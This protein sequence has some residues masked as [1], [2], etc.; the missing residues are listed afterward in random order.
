MGRVGADRGGRVGRRR[1]G[2]PI[3]I[4]MGF[5]GI[6]RCGQLRAKVGGHLYG[7]FCGRWP[8]IGAN[9]GARLIGW[10]CRPMSPQTWRPY[11]DP[12]LSQIG[13]RRF[14]ADARG[15][16]NATQRPSQSPQ[17]DDLLFLLLVQDVAH[18]DAG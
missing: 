14:P 15:L 7:R 2:G 16:L 4:R 5:A 13:G 1:A 3:G 11:R 12:S 10:V 9:G 6:R 17:R 8:G 18:I